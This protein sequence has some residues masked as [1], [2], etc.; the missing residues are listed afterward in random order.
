M[1]NVPLVP[2][3]LVED[4][5]NDVLLVQRLFRKLGIVHP[6][7]RVADGEQAVHYFEGRGEYADRT[8]FPLP[9]LVL[10]DL[11]LPRLSGFEVLQWIR[12]RPVTR[13]IPVVVLTSSDQM[14]D[15][16]RAYELGANSCLKKPISSADFERL[17]HALNLYWLRWNR[18]PEVSPT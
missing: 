4:D 7:F 15:V 3:L 18:Y 12:S 13:R 5:P 8:R 2:V 17:V 9:S 6:L 16:N 1:A 10:L 14:D 11:K